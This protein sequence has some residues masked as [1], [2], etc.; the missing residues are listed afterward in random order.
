MVSVCFTGC[1]SEIKPV[2]VPEAV[3]IEQPVLEQ[4]VSY[5]P[6]NTGGMDEPDTS[7]HEVRNPLEELPDDPVF[8]TPPTD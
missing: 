3:K 1:S 5:L 4:N 2:S 6:Q 7:F 8:K